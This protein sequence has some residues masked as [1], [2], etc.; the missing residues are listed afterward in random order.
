M[1]SK[2]VMSGGCVAKGT[3]IIMSNNS[4]KNIEDI[5]VGD[6]VLTLDGEHRVSHI[7]NP[8]TLE[9]GNPMCV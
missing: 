5:C 8:D 6:T 4:L 1:Y 7:W 3:Q 2:T 9:E